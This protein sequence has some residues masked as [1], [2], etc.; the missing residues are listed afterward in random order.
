MANAAAPGKRPRSSMAPKLVFDT[1][2]TL[3]LVVG[4]P[5]GSQ[6]INYVARTLVATLDWGLD[7]QA[8]STTV[9]AMSGRRTA[10][11]A[12]EAVVAMSGLLVLGR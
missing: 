6:I 11:R 3:Q 8:A 2:G 7:I 12:S 1:A 5:G 4:S 9:D 10:R